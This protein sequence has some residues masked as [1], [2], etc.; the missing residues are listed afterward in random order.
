[1]QD[2]GAGGGKE[3]TPGAGKEGG[4]IFVQSVC[5]V[6][7]DAFMRRAS[8]PSQGSVCL[9]ATPVIAETGYD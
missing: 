7:G 1:M 3:M 4:V 5:C 6:L 2:A 9:R 8:R